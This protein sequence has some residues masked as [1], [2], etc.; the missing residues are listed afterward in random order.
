MI[1]EMDIAPE[2]CLLVAHRVISLRCGIRSL[3]GHSGHRSKRPDQSSICEYALGKAS[4]NQA[5]GVAKCQLRGA[6]FWLTYT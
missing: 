3:L 1:C 2:C 5:L 6:G 4:A